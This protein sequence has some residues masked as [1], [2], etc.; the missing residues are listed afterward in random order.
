MERIGVIIPTRGDRPEF[1]AQALKLLERQTLQPSHV[2]IVTDVPVNQ[3]KDITRRYRLG[4]ERAFA[5]GMDVVIFIE[6][7]DYYDS[8][9]IRL[10][11][12]AWNAA[13]KPDVFGIGE[14]TYYHL[15]LRNRN[16][17]KHIDRASAFC[18][19]ISKL[20]TFPRDEESFTDIHIWKNSTNKKTC[21]FPKPIAIGIKH[22]IGLCGGIGHSKAMSGYRNPDP[23]LSWLRA[24]VDP[25][26]F[27]FYESISNRV[28]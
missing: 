10:M 15:G 11:M 18:T 2:E 9:Y 1:M 20:P 13:G 25:E 28:R 14:T 5:K 27:A 6:D 23:D 26:S 22:G 3:K 24:N 16:H 21:L 12:E 19:M 17:Q 7:D 8:D 4:C